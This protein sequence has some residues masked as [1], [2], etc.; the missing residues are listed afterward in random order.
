[1]T[2]TADAPLTPA[3]PVPAAKSMTM[4]VDRIIALLL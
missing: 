1:M 3:I 4:N 2:G